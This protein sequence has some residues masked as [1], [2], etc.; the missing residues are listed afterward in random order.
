MVPIEPG[1]EG[2]RHSG[3]G[4]RS[5]RLVGTYRNLR[6][7]AIEPDFRHREANGTRARLPGGGS[8]V[9]IPGMSTT[10]GPEEPGAL[11]GLRE[12]LSLRAGTDVDG[13]IARLS[14]GAHLTA[15]NLWLLVCSAILASIGLDTGS[16]A[17]I[18]GAMLISP[19][20]GPILGVG[21][22]LGVTDRLLL[23]RSLK[24]LGVATL[25][26][27]GTSAA[28]FLL[29]PLAEP[30]AE[31]IARTRP[32]LLDVGVAFFGGVAGVV[33][34]SRRQASLA[35]PGVAIA[36]ALMPPLCTAGF[37]LATLDW[38]FLLGAFYLFGLNAI[39]IALSTFVVVRLLKFP[40]HQTLSADARRRERRV[41]ATVALVATLPSMYFLYDAAVR[42]RENDRIARFVARE[43]ETT[44]RAAP[45]WEHRRVGDAHRLR[46]YVAGRPIDSMAADSLRRS[47]RAYGL[48]RLTLELV[49]SDISAEDLARFQGDVQRDLVRAVAIAGAARDSAAEARARRDTVRLEAAARE[50]AAAFPEV[51]GVTFAPRLD[52]LAPRAEVSPPVIFLTFA[53]AS[54]AGDRRAIVERAQA[55]LRRRLELGNLVVEARP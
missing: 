36:T 19:L 28:Y 29:S 22:G 42:V 45:Q 33:A 34:G 35:L 27:I 20:M 32:T 30:T 24:E 12:R 50:V 25:V 37:G 7:R 9:D 31:M 23:A 18:I 8:G 40:R 6:R 17:V 55:L 39:F 54:G 4:W 14:A 47:L 49:Q 26:A 43:V 13:T 3:V 53:P 38:T 46:I 10:R 21:L 15:E 48:E 5:G 16:S 41:V 51:V 2:H 44:G 11:G 52:L 1:A